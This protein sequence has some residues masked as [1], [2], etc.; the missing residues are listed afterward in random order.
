MVMAA[1]RAYAE[2]VRWLKAARPGRI[3]S[4]RFA[5]RS[6]AGSLVFGIAVLGLLGLFSPSSFNAPGSRPFAGRWTLALAGLVVVCV[7]TLIA[8]R[9][10]LQWLFE[11]IRE[12]FS[13]PLRT[14][15]FEEAADAL[16]ACPAPMQS[17]W[18]ISW[19]WGPALLAA[20]GV[21]FAFSSAYFVVGAVLS[22]GRIGW[23]N[24]IVAGVNALLSLLCFALGAARLA[25]WRLALSVHREVTGRYL[26]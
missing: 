19:V 10:R 16:A 12:P 7:L 5:M 20:G 2:A 14:R 21:T 22:G 11:R 8:F 3:D 26:D 6:F 13:R 24:P 18:A 23:G 15:H 1:R 9:A 4:G 25:T 17:R